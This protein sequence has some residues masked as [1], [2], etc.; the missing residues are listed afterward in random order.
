MAI[1]FSNTEFE[2]EGLEEPL[3]TT[4][5]TRED[6]GEYS[7]RPKTL[8]E[9]IGQEK[10]KGNLEVFIQAAKM[11]HEPLDHVL[12]HGPPGLGKTTL[13]GIIANEM[14]VNVRITSG[15]AIEKAGDLAALLTNLNEND[16]LFVDEIHRLNRAVEE[17]LY[18]AMEDYAIDIIIGKGPSAN[19]IRLDLPR[20]TLIGATTRAGQLSA[21]LR[22][23]FGVTLRLELYSPEELALIVT[24]SA[25]ILEV[26]IEPEGAMEIARRSRGTPRIANR[27]LRRVRDFAQVI[28]DGVITLESARI[29]LDRMEVDEIGL[30]ANDRRMLSTLIKFYK[31]GPVG[32]ETL[33]AAIGE[34]AVTIED[35]YEPYLM[36]IGFLSRTPRGRCATPA[37]YLH[38]GLTPPG[39]DQGSMDQQTLF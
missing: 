3:V 10:A 18:P 30:D 28:S 19:S 8:R 27:M 12:L 33:A 38:L 13:S 2:A 37:A 31:G 32:L 1:D 7:L 26:P 36:Q 15:P 23:R 21:P 22:D 34:E 20:F 39:G 4:S 29:G 17:V 9:Y 14:G 16:I 35:V 25:G 5:L 24:R 6:E 11:R